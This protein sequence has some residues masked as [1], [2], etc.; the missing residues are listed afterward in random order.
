MSGGGYLWAITQNHVSS[1]S[2]KE[3]PRRQSGRLSCS[4]SYSRSWPL[5]SAN[6][7]V[8]T[9]TLLSPLQKLCLEVSTLVSKYPDIKDGHIG[10][11]L[12]TRGDGSQDMKQTIVR[13]LEQGPMAGKPKLCAHLQG[14]HSS[15]S[16]RSGASQV[17]HRFP[18]LCMLFCTHHPH[19]QKCIK[20]KVTLDGSPQKLQVLEPVSCHAERVG[21]KVPGLVTSWRTSVLL[22]VV[23]QAFTFLL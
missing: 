13:N 8:S 5:D 10:T 12:A 4:T 19:P 9:V 3:V 6:M 17:A 20:A 15:E 1:W 18:A 22:A 14:N 11:L 23:P 16:E 21:C 2:T 7:Q